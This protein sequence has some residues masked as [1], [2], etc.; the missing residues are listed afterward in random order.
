[1]NDPKDFLEKA[2]SSLQGALPTS[3]GEDIK[4]NITAVV[5]S[6]LKECDVVSREELEV[7]TA[8]L[9]KTR[10]KLQILEQK[11][12]ELELKLR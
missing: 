8:V 10:E 5:S 6:A 2:L 1:M 12:A 4:K 7:Q 11:L 3:L 9:N